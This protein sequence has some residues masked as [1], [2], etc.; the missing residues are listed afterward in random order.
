MKVVFAHDHRFIPD[1]RKV[2]SESQFDSSLWSRYLKVF[3]G[4]TVVGR[5]GKKPKNKTIHDLIESSADRVSFQLMPNISNITSRILMRKKTIDIM[6]KSLQ[7]VDA[8]I[9]RLPS[10]IGL[11]AIDRAFHYGKPWAVEVVGCP[12]DGLWNYGSL[13]G[14]LYAPISTWRMKQAV[15]K[16][17]FVLYV[18][19]QF[20]QKRYPCNK[21]KT[22][23]CSNVQIPQPSLPV[24]R[25]RLNR[26]NS[27][28]QKKVIFGLIG[29]LRGQFKGIQTVLSALRNVRDELPIFEFRV[30]GGGDADYW[31][32]L[33]KSLGIGDVTFFDGVL[34]GGESVFQWLDKIDIYLQPSFK[35]G[36]PRALIE[37]MSRGCPC[38]ASNVAGIPELLEQENLITPGNINQLGELLVKVVNNRHWQQRQAQRNWQR[39][40]DYSHN[41]L[42]QR[43]NEFWQTFVQS[44][45]NGDYTK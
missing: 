32:K 15:A 22:T 40:S 14:K 16:S 8:V 4:V 2:F 7:D 19:D 9:A 20:L 17:K 26:I 25:E 35:E 27:S 45:N 13:Q 11:L 23:N 38:I 44:I 5:L 41:V 30:L 6:D 43:R 18:T 42:E 29:T 12:W 10:E 1:E 31:E 3:D 33:A 24:L 28:G 21:G 39:A 36:L 34:P 37:A